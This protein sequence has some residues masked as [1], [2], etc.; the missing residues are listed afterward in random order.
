MSAPVNE[1]SA[2]TKKVRMQQA[3]VSFSSAFSTHEPSIQEMLKHWQSYDYDDHNIGVRECQC[4]TMHY[5]LSI[6]PSK[7]ETEQMVMRKVCS[8]LQALLT[9]IEANKKDEFLLLPEVFDFKHGHWKSLNWIMARH[10]MLV[11]DA[12]CVP[13]WFVSAGQIVKD[14]GNQSLSTREVVQYTL[15]LVQ[16]VASTAISAEC[17]E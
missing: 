8:E 14:S 16:D 9:F 7:E 13:A 6:D 1:S 11:E 2:P 10:Y 12:A 3:L 17:M 5:A 4:M 15:R